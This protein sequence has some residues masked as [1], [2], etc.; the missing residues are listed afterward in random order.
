MKGIAF[1]SGILGGLLTSGIILPVLAQVTS[2]GTTNTTVNPSSNNFNILN[3]IQKGNNL[4]HSFKEFSIPK[5]SSATFNN[6]TNVVN[7]INR[8]TGGNISN[9]DG[10]I[11]ANGSANFFLINP[12][13]IVFGKNASL[14]IGGSFLGTTAESLLFED[15]FEFSAVN[16]QSEPLLTVSVPLG[17]QMGSNPGDIT[18]RGNGHNQTYTTGNGFPFD[19]SN[20]TVGL[21]VL[22][23]KTIGLIGGNILL[24][25]GVLTA[26]GGLIELGAVGQNNTQVV[27]LNSTAKGWDF[28]YEGITNFG[29]I[30]LNERSLVDASGAGSGSIHLQGRKVELN[31]ASTLLIQ[32]VGTTPAGAIQVDATESFVMQG[33]SLEGLAISEIRTGNLDAGKGADIVIETQQLTI[34]DGAQ[35]G[36]R[37]FGSGSGGDIKV[38]STDQIEV[39]GFAPGNSVLV[40]TIGSSNFGSAG[41]SGNV[42]ISTDRL[43]I[44]D[45][46][47]IAPVSFGVSAG[48]NLSVEATEMIEVSGVA[49][50][51]LSSSIIGVIAFASGD[52]GDLTINTA[53]MKV[54]NGGVITSSTLASG[55]AGDLI[56]NAS[57]SVEV[58]GEFRA[59]S[60]ILSST[61]SA[62]SDLSTPTLRQ[63]IGLPPFPTGE[64][65]NLTINTPTLR[66]LNQGTV[67]V[68]ND[69]TSGN[70]G[71]LNINADAVVLNNQGS[72]TALARDGRGGDIVLDAKTLDISNGANIL[73]STESGTGGNIELNLQELLLMRNQ[74]PINTESLGIGNG[75][76]ITINSPIILGLENSD[77]IANAVEGMGGN[78]DITTSGIFGLEFRDSLTPESDIT[79]S[80]QFGING[81]VEIN[82]ISIDPSSG[83]TELP[84]KLTDSSQQISTGCSRNTD[85]AFVATGKGGIPQN[86]NERVDLNRAWS[87]IRDLSVFRKPHNISEI[88]SISTKPVIVEA[89]GFIRNTKGEI[90][91]V[92]VKNK[93]LKTKQIAECS[94]ANAS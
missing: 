35:A 52:A 88:T 2:D 18:V 16:A 67:S 55:A 57:E 61:I 43:K 81:T 12:A 39:N 73:A 85:S 3:G 56:I 66:V 63:A 46:G 9:I 49:A 10:L 79:A 94:G 32:N 72:L 68:R 65:G 89:T 25:S 45:G 44:A 21:E 76:N 33:N 54:T 60:A 82:N 8:V 90:E 74:S 31:N 27:N 50:P 7:I 93:P 22:N 28:G 5:G 1:L 92:A 37:T 14:D 40:S 34:R 58:E 80:S 69:G 19:R 26:E 30:V 70:A 38:R 15:G 47:I 62:A 75:G 86:P 48:G 4:F 78:I 24:E 51:T 64:S 36:T 83:L 91:L 87:D 42:S 20:S 41:S 84:V 71:N 13:G 23:G 17:L 59:G 77:I 6:S 53:Q 29:D 11:K